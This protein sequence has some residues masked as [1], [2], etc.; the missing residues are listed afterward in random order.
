MG[1][2]YCELGDLDIT[3]ITFTIIVTATQDG[4]AVNTTE[5]GSDISDP[6]PENKYG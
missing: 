3:T 1:M 2:V 6:D 5:V 4:M